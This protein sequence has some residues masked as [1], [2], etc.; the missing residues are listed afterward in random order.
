[1]PFLRDLIRINNYFSVQIK[2]GMAS[3][4]KGADLKKLNMSPKIKILSLALGLMI[5]VVGCDNADLNPSGKNVS[6]ST[7]DLAQLSGQLEIG[8][9]H[10]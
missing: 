2:P 3:C 8:R 4:V 5:A 1:M 9:A 7:L 10:V 6:V